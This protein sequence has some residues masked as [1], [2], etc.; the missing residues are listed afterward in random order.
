[1]KVQSH[2]IPSIYFKKKNMLYIVENLVLSSKC[3]C[4]VLLKVPTY[5]FEVP[6]CIKI[7]CCTYIPML[8]PRKIHVFLIIFPGPNKLCIDLLLPEQIF[9]N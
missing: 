1:M 8:S 2:Y 5:L 7:M 6:V 4:F 9:Q 3:V